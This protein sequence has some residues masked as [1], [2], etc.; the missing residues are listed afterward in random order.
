MQNGCSQIIMHFCFRCTCGKCEVMDSVEE[1]Y[2]CNER[3]CILKEWEY[4]DGYIEGTCIIEHPGFYCTCLNESSLRAAH[5]AYK[6]LYG[7]LK[8]KTEDE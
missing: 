5:N 6:H 8:R 3:Q 4:V 1:S 2:C 7:V